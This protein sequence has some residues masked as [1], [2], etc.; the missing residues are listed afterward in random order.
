MRLLVLLEDDLD[1]KEKMETDDCLEEVGDLALETQGLGFFPLGPRFH[2]A[3][4]L[5]LMAVAEKLYR[6]IVSEDQEDQNHAHQDNI[7]VPTSK[8]NAALQ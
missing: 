7:F 1:Q 6:L 5:V 2:S 4:P 3:L 8:I